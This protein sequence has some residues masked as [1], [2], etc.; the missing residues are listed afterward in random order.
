M[1]HLWLSVH[2]F[3]DT[4]VTLEQVTPPIAP[5]GKLPPSEVCFIMPEVY[6]AWVLLYLEV[7]HA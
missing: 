2:A 4:D 1:S 6:H 5:A 7:C 3:R